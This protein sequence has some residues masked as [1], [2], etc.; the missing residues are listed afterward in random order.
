MQQ[1]FIGV[2]PDAMYV[3]AA[4]NDGTD[5]DT[6]SSAPANVKANNTITVAASLGVSSL[7]TFSN[8]GATMVDLAAPGVG[9]R[10]TVPGGLYMQISGTSQAT[11][12]VTNIVGQVMDTNPKLSIAEVKK[13]VLG[14]VDK[15]DWLAGKV[16]S[17]GIAN[18]DRALFAAK[19]TMSGSDLDSAIAQS[20]THV[21]DIAPT[22]SE[23]AVQSHASEVHAVRM[24]SF[25]QE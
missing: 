12:Y 25:I 21:A 15:K 10:S 7:A 9:I 16:V 14:T 5:N 20:R 23:L 19:L 8:Y 3:I 11:P 2:A 22:Q 13:L 17:G 18:P 4:G 6:I 1:Q 24:P